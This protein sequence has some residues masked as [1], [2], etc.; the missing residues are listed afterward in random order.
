[1]TYGETTVWWE[2]CIEADHAAS[3]AGLGIYLLSNH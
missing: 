2:L 1:M 3:R